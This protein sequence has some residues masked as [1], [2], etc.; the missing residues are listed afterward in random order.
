MY[1]IETCICSDF[2][3]LDFFTFSLFLTVC[4]CVPACGGLTKLFWRNQKVVANWPNTINNDGLIKNKNL[5]LVLYTASLVLYTAVHVEMYT[6]TT[7][8]KISTNKN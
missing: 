2:S 6:P 3:L 4:C 5:S 1:A 8:H 7:I